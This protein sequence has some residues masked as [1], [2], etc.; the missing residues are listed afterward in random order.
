MGILH[1]SGFFCLTILQSSAIP[2]SS[3]GIFPKGETLPTHGYSARAGLFPQ[4]GDRDTDISM[5]RY[6]LAALRLGHPP[7]RGAPRGDPVSPT[8]ILGCTTKNT[9]ITLYKDYSQ[10][11]E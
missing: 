8:S 6:V 10:S 9:A 1:M 4:A 11:S 5:G 3:C 7:P 2:Q